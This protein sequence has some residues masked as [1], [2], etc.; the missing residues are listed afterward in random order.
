MVTDV[1]KNQFHQIP[2][3]F[4]LFL[5]PLWTCVMYPTV[6]PPPHRAAE[7]SITGHLELLFSFTVNFSWTF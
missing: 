2:N 1:V 5:L 4:I 6:S 3:M 7:M